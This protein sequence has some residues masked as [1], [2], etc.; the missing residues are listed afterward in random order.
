MDYR[1]GMNQDLSCVVDRRPP[2]WADAG[3]VPA[4]VVHAE[5]AIFTSIRTPMGEGYRIIACSP[6]L[7]VD[8]RA[9]ITRRSPSHGSICD[10]DPAAVALS[11]Y[12]LATGRHCIAWT[13][14]AGK[15]H[16]ARGG[17]RVYTRIALLS[18]AG[19]H[20]FDCHPFGVL[21]ALTSSIGGEPDLKSTSLPRLSLAANPARTGT[22]ESNEL[23][24][25]DCELMQFR[26]LAHAVHVPEPMLVIAGENMTGLLRQVIDLLS[27]ADRER[28]SCSANLYYA[29][30]REFQLTIIDRVT[31]ETRRAVQGRDIRLIEMKDAT[32]EHG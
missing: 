22:D 23:T 4:D 1:S 7:S 16:T 11:S 3:N 8:E 5:Q 24:E 21:D 19:F 29:A 27:I 15:E 30:S 31:P 17:L 9:E 14:Y 13:R 12:R 32:D 25:P 18:T 10:S 2:T 20:G 6:G 26:D 28:L